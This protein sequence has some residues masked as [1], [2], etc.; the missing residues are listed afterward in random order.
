M[1]RIP[2]RVDGEDSDQIQVSATIHGRNC[3]VSSK[4]LAERI[5]KI[6]L[7]FEFSGVLDETNDVVEWKIVQGDEVSETV[8]RFIGGSR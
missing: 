4:K 7:S 8:S 5:I 6:D 2:E 3:D 1:L